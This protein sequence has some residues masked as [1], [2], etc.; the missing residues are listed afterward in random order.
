MG[1]FRKLTHWYGRGLEWLLVGT[2]ALFVPAPGYWGRWRL[3]R[4]L[5]AR[6]APA[7]DWA[8]WPSPARCAFAPSA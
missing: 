5:P 1:W 4:R 3:P 6:P 7:P 8:V 2:V